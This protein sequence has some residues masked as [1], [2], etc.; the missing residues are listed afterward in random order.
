M[1]PEEASADRDELMYAKMAHNALKGGQSL[2]ESLMNVSNS[3]GNNRGGDLIPSTTLNEG[4]K[5]VVNNYLAENFGLIVE[6]SI[7]TTIL[8]MY[9]VERIKD[10]L[11]EYYKP[12]IKNTIREVFREMKKEQQEKQKL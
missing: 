11:N 9:A 6:E 12:M 3:G 10:V 8:D 7:K 4:V 5:N 1:P 2:S